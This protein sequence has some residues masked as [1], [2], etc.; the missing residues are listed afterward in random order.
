VSSTTAQ[1]RE[2]P[3]CAE[4]I[5]EDSVICPYCSEHLTGPGG[6]VPL[7]RHNL[8]TRF[9]T[10]EVPFARRWDIS[11]GDEELVATGR[12]EELRV[13]RTDAARMLELTAR[14]LV[15]DTGTGRKKLPLDD[16]GYLAAEMWLTGSVTPRPSTVGRDA[17]IT[18][19]VGIFCC[20]IVLGIYALVRAG[21]AQKAINEYPELITGQGSVTAAKV[22]GIIDLVLFALGLIARVGQISQL[23]QM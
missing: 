13:L 21:V 17:L 7:A 6:G 18:A 14:H 3:V 15:I 2:C 8:P 23:S 11:L 20:Q 1:T 12:T 10:A 5:P 19:I 9:R 4:D 22:I 16:V